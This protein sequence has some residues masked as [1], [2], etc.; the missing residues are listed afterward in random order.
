MSVTLTTVDYKRAIA[1][2]V[3]FAIASLI[4]LKVQRNIT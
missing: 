2:G 3:I 1:Y 4:L